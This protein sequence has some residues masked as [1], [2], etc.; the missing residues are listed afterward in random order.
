[1]SQQCKDMV[2]VMVRKSSL[3]EE[4]NLFPVS[5]EKG[6]PLHSAS[7][8]N[9]FKSNEK[10]SNTLRECHLVTEKLCTPAPGWHEIPY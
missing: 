1:M 6:G 2:A 10:G 3:Q 8:A 5:V 9:Y 7:D 4:D